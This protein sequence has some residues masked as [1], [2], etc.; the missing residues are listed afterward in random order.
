M[1]NLIDKKIK[2][3][4]YLGAENVSFG[5]KQLKRELNEVIEGE[6]PVGNALLQAARDVHPDVEV[7]VDKI[8][9]VRSGLIGPAE[10]KAVSE[11]MSRKLTERAPVTGKFVQFWNQ[12]AKA[13]VEE[14][15]K[16]DIPWVTFDGK[17]LYQRY[18]PKVQTS[19]EFRDPQTGRMV[20]NIYEAKAEDATLLGKASI[21][22][23]RIGLGVNGNHMND[24]SIVRQFHLWGANSGIPTATIHDAFF[25]NIGDAMRT[26]SALRT[27]Y[28][29]ALEGNTIE[30]TL[31]AMR[32]EGLS[33]SSYERLLALA[34]KEGLIDPPNAITRQDI[35]AP[36]P[37]GMD[38]YGIGP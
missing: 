19:I 5:L 33:R 35:L 7:F 23:A 31:K 20:R 37:R 30:K 12:A 10:F 9:N 6:A 18:R 29:D 38:W 27:I 21:S 16:V 8:S 14:T 28:A 26:K 3:A 32:D 2:D 1:T 34:K 24:A 22:R 36:I 15:Q 4:D 11:I 17:R 13:F 25:T